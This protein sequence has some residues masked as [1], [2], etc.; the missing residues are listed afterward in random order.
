[1]E[2]QPAHDGE[3]LAYRAQAQDWLVSWLPPTWELDGRRHGAAGICLPD[4]DSV[5]LVSSDGMRWEL[6]A[7]R[8][9]GAE[10]WEETLRREVLEEACAR[11]LSARL[12]GF[13]RGHCIAGHERGL[14][15]VRSVWLADVELAPWKPAFETLHRKVVPAREMLEQISPGSGHVRIYRRAL[16]E[17]GFHS[18][19]KESG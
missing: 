7:G 12:L 16:D 14:V 5:V 1:M 6:P 3:E 2:H 10:S 13:S 4:P 11:V 18:G 8:P 17:A 15:L 19:E 9:E